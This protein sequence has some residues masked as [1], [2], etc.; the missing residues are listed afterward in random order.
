MLIL[1]AVRAVN[2]IMTMIIVIIALLILRVMFTVITA[3]NFER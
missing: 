3:P 1:T 2:M